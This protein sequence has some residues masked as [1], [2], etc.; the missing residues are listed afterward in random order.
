MTDAILSDELIATMSPDQ[1]RELIH[2]LERPLEELLPAPALQ[3]VRR[4]RLVLMSAGAVGLIPWTIYLALT[5]PDRY[6]TYDWTATWVGFDVLLLMFM[7]ST[8]VLGLFRRQLVMM[9]AFTT[10]VLLICD[11]WFDVMTAAPGDVWFSVVTAGL[12]ELPLA[13]LL[14]TGALRILR[15]TANRFWLLSPH[16]PLWRVPLLP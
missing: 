4:V 5:L 2:R 6:V 7:V 9:A 16:A 3:R 8:A 1:R 15:L 11:A 13:V 10:G 14:I 12:V